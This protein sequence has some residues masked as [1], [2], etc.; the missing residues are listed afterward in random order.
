MSNNIK[1]FRIWYTGLD[2]GLYAG[3]RPGEYAV[4]DS[5]IVLE[6]HEYRGWTTPF[7]KVIIQ[8][9][10]GLTDT[11][12]RPIYVGDIV[13]YKAGYSDSPEDSVML[14]GVV[15]FF[16]KSA[17]YGLMSIEDYI[18]GKEPD[19]VTGDLFAFSSSITE[20]RVVGNIFE[21][22]ELLKPNDEKES[23]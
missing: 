4:D 10:I 5:G 16:P 12:N 1:P 9:F 2:D 8:Y 3:F 23:H 15:A 20:Y 7:D 11:T 17:A 6:Y 13:S 19:A 14:T 18:A 21:N 22:P